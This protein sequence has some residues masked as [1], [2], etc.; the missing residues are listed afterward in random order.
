MPIKVVDNYS[1]EVIFKGN[2]SEFL[3]VNDY[4]DDLMSCVL[5]LNANTNMVVFTT[6]LGQTYNIYKL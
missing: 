3:A 4:D 2:A 5:S 6:F 1:N